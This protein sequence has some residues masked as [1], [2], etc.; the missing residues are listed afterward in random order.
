MPYINTQA[1]ALCPRGQ[2]P[3]TLNL[4]R[5]HFQ[6]EALPSIQLCQTTQL[7]CKD[8]QPQHSAD[9]SRCNGTERGE[10]RLRGGG[11]LPGARMLRSKMRP[12]VNQPSL[13]SLTSGAF[14]PEAVGKCS[15]WCSRITPFW[16]PTKAEAS[17]D[18]LWN[19]EKGKPEE[20]SSMVV[21]PPH[22]ISEAPFLQ[23]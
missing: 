2:S 15:E 19:T 22:H 14:L 16:M 5:A 11:E 7:L 12:A 4:K 21:D 23:L 18:N 9:L 13:D 1:F 3:K 17:C 8:R 6:E 20:E 10:Q